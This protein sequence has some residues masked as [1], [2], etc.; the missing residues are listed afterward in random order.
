MGDDRLP[1]GAVGEDGM[2]LS[3]RDADLLR[4]LDYWHGKRAQRGFP[5]RGDIDPID[6]RFMLERIALIEVHDGPR[7]RYRLRLVGSWWAQKYGFEP[8]GI[9]LDEWPNPDQLKLVLA[10]YERLI[11]LRRPLVLVRDHWIDEKLLN[12]EA[13]LLPLSEDDAQLTMIVAGIGQDQLP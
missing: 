6:L 2:D 10:T 7:R 1:A 9:W 12:Y 8:T 11:A 4:L 5:R 13:A 3:P